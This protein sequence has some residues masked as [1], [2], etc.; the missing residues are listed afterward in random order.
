[1]NLLKNVKRGSPLLN[2]V[3]YRFHIYRI[4]QEKLLKKLKFGHIFTSF[5][6]KIVE[7]FC[8]LDFDERIL[9]QQE[10]EEERKRQRRERKKEKK[11]ELI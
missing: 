9:K 4:K 11:V 8:V 10:E 6:G 1:M 5:Y 2:K 3:S 7:F